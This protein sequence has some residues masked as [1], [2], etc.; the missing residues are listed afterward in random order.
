MEQLAEGLGRIDVAQVVQHH[1]PEACVEQVQDGVLGAA[2]VEVDAV[3]A[4]PIGLGLG[5]AE[6]IVVVR[7]GVA[8]VVPAAARPAGHGVGLAIDHGLGIEG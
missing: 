1:V 7:V 2:D 5:R 6:R 3:I 4:Q 8:Q